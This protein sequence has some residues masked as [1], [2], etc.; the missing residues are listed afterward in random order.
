MRI[1]PAVALV[2][3]TVA[4]FPASSAEPA[5]DVAPR[6]EMAACP[7]PAMPERPRC[8]YLIADQS[9][10]RVGGPKIKVFFS[11]VPSLAHAPA[12]DPIVV[13]PGGPGALFN[14][15]VD[16]V[17]SGLAELRKQRDVI[18]VDQR[19][20]GRSEPHL[21]CA[22]GGRRES[23]CL[24]RLKER[25]IDPADFNTEETA[26]DLRDLRRALK[27]ERWN[28]M[29]ASYAG[30]VVLRL[31]QIDP[32]GTRA[33]VVMAP[34]PLAP[35]L[36]RPDNAEQRRTAWR[37]LV[38]E[39]TADAR[40]ARQGDIGEKLRAI[41]T[42]LKSEQAPASI[43]PDLFAQWRRLDRH[44][45]GI[46]AALIRRLDWPDEL[47]RLPRAVGELFEFLNGKIVLDRARLDAIY[48]G[49]T[50][51]GDGARIPPIDRSFIGAIV[52]C[53]EDVLPARAAA[54]Q[55]NGPTLG[56]GNICS[57]FASAP[58]KDEPPAQPPP[59]L[60]QTGAYDV[61]TPT[62]WSDEIAAQVP[63]SILARMGDTGHGVSY[64]H[65]CGN[66]LMTAFIADPGAPL[67]LGCVAKH[68]RPSFAAP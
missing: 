16:Y 35:S 65:P 46:E 44:H 33:A 2:L 30:R 47:P 31:M 62:A 8:G 24:A 43:P 51:A 64:R 5:A 66:A 57:F 12:A 50:K 36:A 3:A 60:I 41:A 7:W 61:R 67:D 58:V 37:R 4:T 20:V 1:C 52:R 18:L 56:P 38:A 13:L 21:W 63:G 29:G 40:C 14:P 10:L 59:L 54:E 9:R 53:R 17:M 6:V 26:H 49:E 68:A 39:C 28:A 25:G 19:G 48:A 11:I 23:N 45:G 34:L 32:Q 27:H 55:G 15:P 42:A 22:N